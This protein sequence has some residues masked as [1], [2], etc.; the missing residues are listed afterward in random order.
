MVFGGPRSSPLFFVFSFIY[1]FSVGALPALYALGAAYF[2]ALGRGAEL[3]ALF[4]ALAIWVQLGEYVSYSNL[5]DNVWNL[6]YR[7]QWTAVFLVISL[8]LL[9]PDGPPASSEEVAV[10]ADTNEERV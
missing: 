3:G 8:L 1:P 6:D 2:L 5:D 4:G 9:V 10:D 7:L